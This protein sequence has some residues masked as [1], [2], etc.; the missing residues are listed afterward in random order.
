MRKHAT[1]V[2]ATLL[3]V[4]GCTSEPGEITGANACRGPAVAEVAT[5]TTPLM[6]WTPACTVGYL[7]VLDSQFAPTWT[8]V[9]SGPSL[10]PLN[11]IRSGVTY[12]TVP[13]EAQLFGAPAAPLAPGG[14]YYLLLRVAGDH[15]GPGLLVDTV[16]F[17]P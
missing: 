14:K 13:P 9:D 10:P 5:G 3:M 1:V 15:G 17:V 6:T 12:G 2:L 11:G 16:T 4:G 7:S 8:I